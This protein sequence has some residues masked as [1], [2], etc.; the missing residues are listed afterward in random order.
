VPILA[1]FRALR[2]D[3]DYAQQVAAPPYDVMSTEE[4]RA[5]ARDRPWSF[6]HVSRPEID[7]PD[8]AD[9]HG[10]EAYAQAGAAMRRMLDAGVLRREVEPALYVY[11][12]TLGDH[13]QT[14]IAGGA[15]VSAYATGAIRKHELTRTAKEDDRVRQI[16]AV[17]AHTGPVM[18]AHRPDG[19][20][21]DAAAGAADARRPDFQATTPD[22]AVHEI[23]AIAGGEAF[24]TLAEA[25][26]ATEALYIADGHHRA[27]A[28]AR[29][30]EHRR[31]TDPEFHPEAPYMRFLAVSFPEDQMRI[32]DYN[33]VVRDLGGR[34][35]PAFLAAV[36]ERFQVTPSD[37]PARPARSHEFGLYLDG[38]WYRLRPK[39]PIAPDATPVARLDVSVLT[40]R[41]LAPILGIED[42]RTDPRIDFVG[43]ARGLDWL[44]TLV[45]RGGMAAAFSLYP[46]A[47]SDLL[48]VA[49]AG[50]IMPPKSTWFEPKLA[51]G[52]LSLSLTTS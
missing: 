28:A 43:G 2:P 8:G 6:L 27:A 44:A 24:E 33:R 21:D 46:T 14:G 1:P 51:D 41:V 47:M 31:R 40:E 48:A 29:I 30:A 5:M 26:E 4:A 52:L 45:D 23:W 37:G 18:L 34:E 10:D 50:Q 25:F 22:G 38:R 3:A 17:G 20:I 7:L 42:P 16:E 19:A 49:D 32:L 39:E 13:V 9:P 35:P 15:S 36:G 11:R 12:I